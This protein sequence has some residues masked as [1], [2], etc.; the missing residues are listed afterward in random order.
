MAEYAE[1][2][3]FCQASQIVAANQNNQGGGKTNNNN[4]NAGKKVIAAKPTPTD[5]FIGMDTNNPEERKQQ[6]DEVVEV[7]EI[8]RLMEENKRLKKTLVEKFE[9]E[10]DQ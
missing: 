3:Y 10:N 7:G 8:E 1:L 9:A 6:S 5:D 2:E 4:I